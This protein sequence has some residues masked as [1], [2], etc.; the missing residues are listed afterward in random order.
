F[1][2][3]AYLKKDPNLGLIF[4][5][6][7][8]EP[9]DPALFTG[10]GYAKIYPFF[11]GPYHSFL[12]LDADTIVVGNILKHIDMSTDFFS[13]AYKPG[14][15]YTDQDME[16]AFFKIDTMERVEGAD[17]RNFISHFFLSGVFFSHKGLI[18][19]DEF[20]A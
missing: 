15:T 18:S 10:W 4:T 20:V 5:R 3:P 13:S 2:I 6:E 19:Y 1:S 11:D 7:I 14:H 17:W 16:N 8:S 9:Y 12:V